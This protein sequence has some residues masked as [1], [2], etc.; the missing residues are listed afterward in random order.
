MTVSEACERSERVAE[1]YRHCERV[2]R[3]EAR[4]FAYGIRLM[5][6]RSGGR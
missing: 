2:V 1:A 4:N 6:P 3:D 5:P